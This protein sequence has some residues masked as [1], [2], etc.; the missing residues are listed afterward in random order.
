MG[1][2]LEQFILVIAIIILSLLNYLYL[3]RRKWKNILIWI[4]IPVSL[5]IMVV[6]LRYFYQ[7]D[8][9]HILKRV[10]IVAV[11]WSIAI[12]DYKEYR[13]PNKLILSGIAMR[14]LILIYELV[15]NIN[16]VLSILIYE[17]IAVAGAV[18]VCLIC[19]VIS[20]GSL[21]MGDLKL[22]IPMGL[23]LGVEGICYAMFVSVFF[24][25]IVSVF[26]LLTKKKAKS[27]QLPFAPFILAGT[28]A[29]II[30]SGI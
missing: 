22:M 3:Q 9:I 10:S 28:F 29:S 11:L 27:D 6:M 25:F 13:I 30:L 26:L 18:I 7:S 17:L 12:S 8:I 2:W 14:A 24:A 4:L 21:G 15:I 19:M 5:F 23:M 16:N 20:R 1:D